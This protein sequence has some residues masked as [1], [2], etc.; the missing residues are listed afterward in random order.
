[1]KIEIRDVD[2]CICKREDPDVCKPLDELKKIVEEYVRSANDQYEEITDDKDAVYQ[3]TNIVDNIG[4][5]IKKYGWDNVFHTSSKP[6]V[7][8]K[9]DGG[10]YKICAEYKVLELN[11]E[12]MA[13]EIDA[14][15]DVTITTN[16]WGNCVIDYDDD[17]SHPTFIR[18]REK[19]QLLGASDFC[20]IV[21]DNVLPI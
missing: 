6:V 15:L 12:K 1:M 20:K 18:D 14:I 9:C 21:T 19:E 7:S 8:I 2:V 17:R 10:Q 5:A 13:M 4:L 11:D 16:G 3:V